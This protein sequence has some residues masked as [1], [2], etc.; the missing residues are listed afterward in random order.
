MEWPVDVALARP[1]TQLPTG[2]WAYEIKVDGHRTVLWR[3]EDGVRLQSRTGRD[4][5][6]LWMDLAMAAMRLPPGVILDGEAVVYVADNDGNARIS[7]EAAQSRALSRPRR[8]RELADRNPATYVAFDVLAHPAAGFPDLRP[9]PYVER[10]QVLLDVLADT[11]PP[12]VPVWSTTDLDEALLWYEALEGT[13]VEGIVAKPLRSPYKAGRVW[14]KVRHADTVDATVVGFTGAARHP[15]ALAVR[16][17]DGRVALSQR[18]TT[19][20]SS[21]VAPRLV[22]LGQVGCGGACPAGPVWR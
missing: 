20:L 10:R 21:V 7:F 13:G 22:G 11:G 12:I 15:K 18:L 19:A 3:T 17:P 8:A 16:L 4:V 14:A 5:T 6:A 2:P 1:V 9:R